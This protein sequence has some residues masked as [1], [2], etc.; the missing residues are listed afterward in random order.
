MGELKVS[1]SC[2]CSVD[3]AQKDARSAIKPI[4]LRF[5]YSL[6]EPMLLSFLRFRVVVRYRLMA[7]VPG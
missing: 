4:K 1:T 2:P 3:I 6:V 5:Y 7:T